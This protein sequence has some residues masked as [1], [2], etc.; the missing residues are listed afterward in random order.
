MKIIVGLGNP[1]KEY[2]KTRH[3]AGAM[4][5]DLLCEKL[6]LPE[7]KSQK[8]FGALISEGAHENE[9]IILTKPQTFMNLSGESVQKLVNFY[10]CPLENLIVIYDDVDLPL[11]EI[12]VR[13]DGSAGSHNGMKSVTQSLGSTAFPR[14]R[15]GIESRGAESPKEQ[16]ISSFVLNPFTKTEL[17]AFRASLDKAVQA[18][19]MI[20]N[21]GVAEAMQEYN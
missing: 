19:M 1:G 6:N 14:V 2:E 10:N 4:C 7:F 5:V 11:G 16:D 12:R 20:L 17:A 3:N 9:K 13:P 21:K 15:I 18:T 8:K